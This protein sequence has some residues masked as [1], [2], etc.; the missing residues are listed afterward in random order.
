MKI[1]SV[2]SPPT[3]FPAVGG[4]T[5]VHKQ[6]EAREVSHRSRW[7]APMFWMRAP[8][9]QSSLCVTVWANRDANGAPVFREP[10]WL[11][12]LVMGGGSMYRFD[13]LTP[14]ASVAFSA[15]ISVILG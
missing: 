4:G 12:G 10:R 11:Q 8:H 3:R 13:I 1:V 7:F 14:V 2:P 15:E 9:T 5:W 6:E